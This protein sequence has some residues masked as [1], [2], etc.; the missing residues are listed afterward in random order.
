MILSET[1]LLGLLS[2]TG[3]MFGIIYGTKKST[4]IV[5]Y[6]LKELE[7]KQDKYNN[8]INRTYKIEERIS[9]LENVK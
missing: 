7:A 4:D 6:R 9:I 1:L 3:T 8:L 2:F 5:E